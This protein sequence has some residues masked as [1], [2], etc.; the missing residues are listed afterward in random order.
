[1]SFPFIL[2]TM[3]IEYPH[4]SSDKSYNTYKEIIE[5]YIDFTKE[6]SIQPILDTAYYYGNTK[7]EQVLGQI[8]NE[9]DIKQEI[10]IATK[11]NP[12][13]NNDFTNGI[14]GQLSKENLERQLM[15]SLK[16]LDV[17]LVDLFYLHCPDYQTPI[18]ETLEKVDELWRR[19]KFNY[20]GISNFSKDQLKEVINICHE[21]EFIFPKYYQGMYNAISRKVEEIFPMLIDNNI[22]F[23]GYNPLAGGLL[24]GKYRKNLD[25]EES[26]FKNNQIYQSIFWKD[27]I[28]HHLD[29][30][31][32]SDNCTE[33]SYEWLL[34]NSKLREND[35]II[36]GVST[37]QQFDN[38]MEM[39]KRN[40]IKRGI[41]IKFLTKF[42]HLNS[43]YKKI[44]SITPNYYY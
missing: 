26:R 1:M 37:P 23:W 25:E 39:I 36:I 11:A 32:Q 33:I 3:N 4:T 19:E 16:H 44:E 10:R 40:N 42:D 7:T 28:L 8:I 38:N 15:T 17:E 6:Y 31:F 20:F 21:N 34:K 27:E 35:K 41:S 24:T 14:L 18:Q 9:L 2:G 22:E 13:Y 29:N 43:V 12:W 30:F 5:K